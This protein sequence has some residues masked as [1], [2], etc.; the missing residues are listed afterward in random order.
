MEEMT[1]RGYKV[2][3]EWWEPTYRGKT[4]LAYPELEE[5]AL[6]TP[7]YPEHH[8]SY[9][10]ECI[11]NLAERDSTRLRKTNQIRFVFLR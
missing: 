8:A 5:E 4:C 6:S 2:S 10:K 7:I 1:A 11:D 9:L 3:P